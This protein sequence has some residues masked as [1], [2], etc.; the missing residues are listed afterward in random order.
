MDAPT[1]PHS[2]VVKDYT[3]PE[4]MF[5]RTIPHVNPATLAELEVQLQ[6]KLRGQVHDLRV[7]QRGSGLALQGYA[8]TYYAK[9]L[10]QH[11]LMEATS[12][13]LLSNEIQVV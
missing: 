4:L 5:D 11:A 13:P 6:R 8:Y 2:Q 1:T 7:L 3:V 9:Q 12:C 10:A